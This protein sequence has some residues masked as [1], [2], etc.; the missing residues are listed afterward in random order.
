MI[1]ISKQ[2]AI[3]INTDKNHFYDDDYMNKK[4]W[5]Y[6]KR[7]NA[8]FGFDDNELMN[9]FIDCNNYVDNVWERKR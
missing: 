4:Y 9:Q 7:N 2:E 8:L 3:K 6:D 5:C 1:E